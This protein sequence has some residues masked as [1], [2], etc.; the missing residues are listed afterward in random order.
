MRMESTLWRIY[1]GTILSCIMAKKASR[2]RVPLTLSEAAAYCTKRLWM[3]TEKQNSG[4][5]ICVWPVALKISLMA[6]GVTRCVRSCSAIWRSNSLCE[7][8]PLSMGM[9]KVANVRYKSATIRKMGNEM[10]HLFLGMSVSPTRK[11]T[12]ASLW[13][14]C[15]WLTTKDRPHLSPA[16]F[17]VSCAHDSQALAA[18]RSN[19]YSEKLISP[20]KSRSIAVTMSPTTSST[21]ASPS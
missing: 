20:S 21:T 10:L 12:S 16:L 2:F 13:S 7:M 15:L 6:S 5:W 9:S 1:S 18:L 4:N 11:A 3:M 14:T 19:S 8:N 17:M